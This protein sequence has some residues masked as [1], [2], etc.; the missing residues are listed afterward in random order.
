MVIDV[1]GR[2]SLRPAP[3]QLVLLCTGGVVA[4]VL[5]WVALFNLWFA[6]GRPVEDRTGSLLWGLAAAGGTLDGMVIT[7]ALVAGGIQ[8]AFRLLTRRP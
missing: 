7:L 5:L 3:A 2:S 8:R 1:N 4:M 6:I